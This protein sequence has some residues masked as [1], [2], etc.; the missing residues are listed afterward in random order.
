MAI[1]YIDGSNGGGVDSAGR[2]LT[3]SDPYLTPQFALDDAANSHTPGN[4]DLF[5]VIGTVANTAD[6]DLSTYVSAAGNQYPTFIS[7]GAT[8]FGTHSYVNDVRATWDLSSNGG[9][10]VDDSNL[11]DISFSGFEMTGMANDTPIWHVD[12]FCN[13]TGLKIDFTGLG[14][15][16]PKVLECDAGCTALGNQVLG[17]SNTSTGTYRLF[18]FSSTRGM[19]SHNYVELEG[20]NASAQIVNLAGYGV[21]HSNTL[22][23]EG[24]VIGIVQGSAITQAFNN[25]VY[26]ATK[27]SQVGIRC[28]S[29]NPYSV[30]N[31]NNH[32]ENLNRGLS[33]AV[34]FGYV[35]VGPN[36][37]FN[38]TTPRHS[39]TD[40]GHTINIPDIELAASGFVDAANGDFRGSTLRQGLGIMNAL[41]NPY[42]PA[43]DIGPSNII[44]VPAN[45]YTNPYYR[46]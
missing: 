10:I 3:T 8:S 30:L 27:A 20:T 33:S 14:F 41:P 4:T 13:F 40:T 36:S 37:Y 6:L 43:C 34:D 15:A 24:S 25:V 26:G 28:S 31:Y 39:L 18:N 45:P 35:V 2:G 21:A 38:V 22:K 5:K 12:N 19:F 42:F 46:V 11:D 7:D 9:Q 1:F 32:F 23:I 29:T 17:A 44:K 16:I